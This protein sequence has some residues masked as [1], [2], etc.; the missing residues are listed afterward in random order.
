MAG[1]INMTKHVMMSRIK[2]VL[3]QVTKADGYIRKTCIYFEYTY[4]ICN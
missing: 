2:V 3:M 1:G 4:H